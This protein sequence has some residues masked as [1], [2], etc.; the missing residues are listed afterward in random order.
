MGALGSQTNAARG[1]PRRRAAARARESSGNRR[2]AR[3][4]RDRRHVMRR[5]AGRELACVLSCALP[6]CEHAFVRSQGSAYG[7]FRKS[8]ERGT[9]N[10]AIEAAA[11]L[12][13][14]TLRDALELCLLLAEKEDA[15]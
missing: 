8:L 6:A 2:S 5:S 15:R 14:V 10:L 11:E 3:Q 9:V 4:S 13:A 12:P 7:R 1:C